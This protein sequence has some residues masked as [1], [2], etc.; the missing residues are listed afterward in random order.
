MIFELN[1][2]GLIWFLL[3]ILI[4]ILFSAKLLRG[5]FPLAEG[6]IELDIF[7]DMA[8]L[9]SFPEGWQ[10]NS[11]SENVTNPRMTN[12]EGLPDLS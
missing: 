9:R 12:E 3:S 8:A 1:T 6:K 10:K 4:E 2:V 7:R 11:A 5:A